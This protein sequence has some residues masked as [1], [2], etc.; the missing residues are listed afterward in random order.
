[1]AKLVAKTYSKALFEFAF[2]SDILDEISDEFDFIVNSLK[3]YDE[4]F[5]LFKSP[6]LSI[7][8]RK[9]IIQE[10]FQEKVSVEMLN[11]LF[12]LLD[13][14]RA[15]EIINVNN[16]FN[17]LM[18]EHRGIVQAFVKSAKE[19]DE[20][21]KKELINELSKLIGKGIRLKTAVDTDI[22]GGLYIKI[23][24]KVIDGSVKNK[25]NVIKE[26]LKRIIV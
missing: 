18:D 3:T 17:K 8:E 6:K 21:E 16:E 1:M 4:F 5:E 22:I 19:L 11:F 13:K 23:E 7:D 12:V 10:V 24:D 2:E 26:E 14:R 9:N 20:E 25:L 15:N